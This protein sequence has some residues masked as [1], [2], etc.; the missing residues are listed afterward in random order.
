MNKKAATK[1]ILDVISSSENVVQLNQSRYFK[2]NKDILT[3]NL[4]QVSSAS[5]GSWHGYHANVYYENLEKPLPGHSFNP[6][7]GL[8]NL[9]GRKINW[10]EFDRDVVRAAVVEGLDSDYEEKL[11]LIS[12]E[13]K[14]VYEE[15]VDSLTTLVSVLLEN[16]QTEMLKEIADEVKKLQ[17]PLSQNEII[18]LWRPT[19]T[20]MS[21][22]TKAITQGTRVPPHSE[23]EAKYLSLESPFKA[24]E[25]VIRVARKLHKYMEMQDLLEIEV[26]SQ[27]KRV[28]IGHGQSPLWRELQDFI[29]NRLHLKWDEFN[30][31][32]AAGLATIERLG[33]MLNEACFAFLVLTAEDQYKDG[34]IRARQNV[35]HEV[36]LFQGKLGF[37]K[38]IVLLEEGCEE[39]SNITGMV[40]VRF[41]KENISAKFEEIRRVL[42][43]EGIIS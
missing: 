31:E 23:V 11:S 14:S 13:A 21:R 35:V 20:F 7:W 38:A 40:Q 33:S 26:V 41:P 9:Y 3:K 42:E 16:S 10:Q 12:D 37:R 22:D 5:S 30:R 6:E 2:K 29:Q 34:S 43:R 19:G 25:G 28:F 27:G 15:N 1:S 24:L 4:N 36:G 39:F 18:A 17:G 32:P 8:I